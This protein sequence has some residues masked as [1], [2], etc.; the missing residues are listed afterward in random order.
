MTI[1]DVIRRE[2]EKTT[3][4]SE[5]SILQRFAFDKLIN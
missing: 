2:K 5:L 3:L 4:V 1:R